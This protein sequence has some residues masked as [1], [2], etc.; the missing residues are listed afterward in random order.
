MS[1][2]L[3]GNTAATE[4]FYLQTMAQ[5]D[6]VLRRLLLAPMGTA[7]IPFGHVWKASLASISSKLSIQLFFNRGISFNPARILEFQLWGK[8]L[9][10]G[11]KLG[12]PCLDAFGSFPP[13]GT[14]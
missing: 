2:W 1:E 4:K 7:G 12:S 14:M 3:L 8:A 13:A 5:T 10:H 11:E 6:S 9:S